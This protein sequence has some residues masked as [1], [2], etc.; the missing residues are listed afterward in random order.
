MLLLEKSIQRPI[1][2]RGKTVRSKRKYT[3]KPREPMLR[4]ANYKDIRGRIQKNYTGGSSYPPV[5]P[6]LLRLGDLRKKSLRRT[7][8]LRGLLLASGVCGSLSLSVLP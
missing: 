6:D 4:H 1:N 8:R 3:R 2:S 5:L 7:L